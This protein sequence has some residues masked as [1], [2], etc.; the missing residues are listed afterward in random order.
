M[1]E[2]FPPDLHNIINHKRYELGSWNFERMS[3]LPNM[4]C[5]TCHVSH[6]MHHM[7]CVNCHMSHFFS[8]FF[9]Q[10]GEAYRWRVCYQWGLPRLVFWTGRTYFE[11]IL[12]RGCYPILNRKFAV[13]CLRVS[14]SP[15]TSPWILTQ[16]SYIKKN[17]RFFVIVE[18][19]RNFPF[20]FVFIIFLILDFWI[21]DF[22]IF[23]K[24]IFEIFQIKKKIFRFSGFY[25]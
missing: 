1:S 4:S 10:C 23:L 7:S 16:K 8:S 15:T 20:F 18:Y 13:L 22:M 2:P 6:V 17:H 24:T 14:Q 21:H 9:W 11:W 5:V 19:S 25:Y 12:K 3:T